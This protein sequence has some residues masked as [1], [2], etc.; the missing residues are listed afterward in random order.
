MLAMIQAAQLP[1]W[2]LVLAV[3]VGVARAG[4]L[5]RHERHA[6]APML[7]I[8]FWTNKVIALGNFGS[9][10]IGAVMMSVTGFLPT[11]L[12][13]VMGRGVGDHRHELGA[14]S[15]SWAMASV[16]AG[17]LMLRTSYRTTAMLGGA[18]LAL[19]S[20]VLVLLTPHQQ[21]WSG[22]PRRVAGRHRHGLLQH[23]LPRLGAG[24][25]GAARARRGDGVEHVHAHRRPV[26]RR[27][28]VRRAVNAGLVHYAPGAGDVADRLMEPALRQASAQPIARR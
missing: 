8:R 17:R 5:V 26:D 24:R 11:F 19:G 1:A 15:I 13:G 28:A 7:P 20:A 14:M 16:V 12:Q 2:L 22:R 3:A 10:A 25:G 21:R 18:M 4:L 27:R 6:P 9:F 23:D